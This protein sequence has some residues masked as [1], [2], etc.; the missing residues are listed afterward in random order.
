V[1]TS[2]ELD[3]TIGCVPN[4]SPIHRHGALCARIRDDEVERQLAGG[5][6]L[7]PGRF[8]FMRGPAADT[9]D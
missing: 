1:T 3:N 7:R 4:G 5:A 9:G 2:M 6:L 8:V